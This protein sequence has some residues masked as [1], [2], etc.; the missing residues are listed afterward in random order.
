[1]KQNLFHVL[2]QELSKFF[3]CFLPW[4]PN[5]IGLPIIRNT[6]P[7]THCWA[8]MIHGRVLLNYKTFLPSC[9]SFLNTP[10]IVSTGQMDVNWQNLAMKLGSKCWLGLI[11]LYM[12]RVESWNL[13]KK[14]LYFWGGLSISSFWFL[15]G[16]NWSIFVE[17][18]NQF[19][20]YFFTF[21]LKVRKFII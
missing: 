18:M 3:F 16:E 21:F 11:S 4:K 17:G 12:I 6:H 10:L 1:M 5:I 20:K 13:P 19:L 7:K 8:G 15:C 2:S 14:Y 9:P